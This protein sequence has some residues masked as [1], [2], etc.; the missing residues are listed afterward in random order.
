M[1]PTH[2]NSPQSHLSWL[3]QSQ[4]VPHPYRGRSHTVPQSKPCVG[5]GHMKCP[6]QGIQTTH[7]RPPKVVANAPAL[8][9]QIMAPPLPLFQHVPPYPGPLYGARAVPYPINDASYASEPTGNADQGPMAN[10]IK[11]DASATESNIICFG[12][13]ADKQKGTHTMTSP[14]HSLLCHSQVTCVFFILYHYETNA[15]LA[16]PIANLEGNTIFKEYKK[17]FEFL[18]SKGHKIR[19]NVIDNQASCLIKQFL[20][21]NK[22]D[23]LLVE[24]R[25]HCVNSPERS[26]QTFKDHFISGLATMDSEFPL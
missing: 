5:K 23:L 19:L 13:L 7:P 17:Q 6:H 10:V 26:I 9:P 25:N 14:G 1:Q 15:I 4:R 3:S 8:A 12:A 20:T 21:K 11:G 2:I 16:L 18:E 22:C 24:P